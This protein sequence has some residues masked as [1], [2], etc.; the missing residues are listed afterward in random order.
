MTAPKPPERMTKP[1]LTAGAEI[2]GQLER[3]M[4][5]EL[6]PDRSKVRPLP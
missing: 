1:E 5:V 2:A 4:L 6:T 3:K